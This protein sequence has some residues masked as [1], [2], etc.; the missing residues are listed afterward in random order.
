[1]SFLQDLEVAVAQGSIESRQRALSYATDQLIAGRYTDDEI[2]M[3]GEVI[4]LLERDIAVAA[5]AQLAKRLA[6]VDNAPTSIIN[7]LAFD[8]SIDVAGPVLRESERLDTQ[9]LVANARA[10]SQ[11]HLFPQF[12]ETSV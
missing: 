5:R 4:G 2:W 9:A 11:Q 10:K 7:K 12:N 6:R 1:M 3:C 8:D